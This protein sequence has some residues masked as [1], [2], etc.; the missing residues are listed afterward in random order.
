MDYLICNKSKNYYELQPGE[1]LEDF[2]LDCECGGKLEL[3][4]INIHK[5]FT[6][7]IH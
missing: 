1:S 2:E 5:R 6:D 7:D 4:D 3:K